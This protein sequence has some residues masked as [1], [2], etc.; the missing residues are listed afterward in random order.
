MPAYNAARYVEEAVRSILDQEGVALRLLVI[1]DG[2]TDGTADI[3]EAIGDPRVELVRHAENRGIA[4]RLNEG[5]ARVDTEFTARMDADDISFP[6]RLARQLELLRQRPNVDLVSAYAEI[7]FDDD[8][9]RSP[10]IGYRW[11]KHDEIRW[12]LYFTTSIAHPAM[13]ARTEALRRG[14]P[15]DLGVPHAEDYEYWCRNR[16]RLVYAN[17]PAPL[18][19]WRRHSGTVSRQFAPEQ[20]EATLRVHRRLVEEELGRPVSAE[21]TAAMRFMGREHSPAALEA[22]AA[23]L[24]ELADLEQ[25]RPGVDPETAAW[26]QADANQRL[27]GMWFTVARKAPRRA[28]AMAARWL[29]RERLGGNPLGRG[30]RPPPWPCPHGRGGAPLA[31]EAVT[32]VMS[33]YNE[34]SYVEEALRSVLDQDGARVTVLIADD[35]SADG[36]ADRIEGMRDPRIRLA[37]NERNERNR[38]ISTAVN[39]LFP[40]VETP[41]IARM[42]SDDVS[43]PGR[44]AAQLAFLASHPEVDL[45]GSAIE[46]FRDEPR[47]TAH[48]MINPLRHELIRWAMNFRCPIANDSW[49]ARREA[50][51]RALPY[52]P[53]FPHA[54]DYEFWCRN[55]DVLTLANL[56]DAWVR[57]R[58]HASSVSRQHG[59]EQG[60]VARV[61]HHQMLERELGHSIDPSDA[62]LL[63]SHWD[64]RDVDAIERAAALLIEV[65]AKT[66]ERPGLDPADAR[67]IR[68]DA[69]QRLRGMWFRAARLEPQRGPAML[70]RWL[71]RERLRAIG[72]AA[73]FVRRRGPARSPAEAHGNATR[74]T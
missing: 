11:S 69:D 67:A 68:A 36:T 29:G 71:A 47:A 52:D 40:Q 38:G 51:E 48:T 56:P 26:I 4:V 39:E 54:E 18:I 28:P 5:Y 57:W 13:F 43:R 60:R 20:T 7:V 23:L 58:R 66:L 46:S 59:A 17:V 25:R 42:D 64:L 44:F 22:G 10:V 19:R 12:T 9:Q 37:R 50:L 31:M 41:Y 27:R 32:V 70:G 33:A 8:S 15:I 2:S 63:R 65:E 6:G 62:A 24:V 14:G 34:A 49:M 21:A 35:G 73:A 55:R 53:N 61:A 3:V 1:D 72:S 30:V 16:H 45:V 74:P